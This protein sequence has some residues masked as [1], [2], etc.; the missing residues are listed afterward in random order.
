[1]AK[2]ANTPSSKSRQKTKMKLKPLPKG[3]LPNRWSTSCTSKS[4]ATNNSH[5]LLTLKFLTHYECFQ[6]HP[7]HL[8]QEK[9]SHSSHLG[10]IHRRSAALQGLLQKPLQGYALC[11]PPEEAHRAEHLR[12]LPHP[13]LLRDCTRQGRRHRSCGRAHGSQC[14]RTAHSQSCAQAHKKAARPTHQQ[15]SQSFSVSG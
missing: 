4:I 8:W 5:I 14:G 12:Q 10:R 7:H 1:M 15:E 6:S 9:R 3:S 11:L 2:M 13:R